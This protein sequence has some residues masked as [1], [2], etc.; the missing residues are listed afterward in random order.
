[1]IWNT[2]FFWLLY[3]L[4]RLNYAARHRN[5]YFD[6]VGGDPY[7]KDTVLLSAVESIWKYPNG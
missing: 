6:S 3:F 5:V 2:N 1:M 4:A 7:G